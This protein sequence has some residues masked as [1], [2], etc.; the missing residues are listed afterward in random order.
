MFTF[1]TMR[2]SGSIFVEQVMFLYSFVYHLVAAVTVNSRVSNKM[3]VLMSVCTITVIG[4][5]LLVIVLKRKQNLCDTSPVLFFSQPWYNSVLVL[6]MQF[7][8]LQFH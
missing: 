3:S 1:V 8:S 2:I 4:Y 6:I 7:S 5:M